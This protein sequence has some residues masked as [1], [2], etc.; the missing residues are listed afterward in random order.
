MAEWKLIIFSGSDASLNNLFVKSNITNKGTVA[1]THLTG[2]FTGSFRGDGSQLT[3]LTVSAVSSYTNPGNDRIITSVDAT[4]ING[5]ANLTFN[6]SVLGV[7]GQINASSYITGSRLRLST[8]PADGAGEATVLVIDANGNVKSDEIDTRVW[9]TTLVDYTGTPAASR[10]AY[11]SDGDTITA[12]PSMSFA[13][14]RMRVTGSLIVNGAITGS[15]IRLN[16][17]AAGLDNTVLVIT[18]TGQVVTDEIDARVWGTTLVDGTG[19]ANRLAYWS[20]ADSLT[21]NANLSFD[22]SNLRVTGSVKV[23]GA[24]TGSNIRLNNLAAGLDNTVLVVTAT[25]QVVTDEIDARVWGT[26]LVDGTGANTRVAYWSDADTLTSAA[27]FTYNGTVVQVGNSTFGTNTFVAGN[28]LVAGT[29]SFQHT[30]TL[31]VSDRFILLNSGSNTGDGGI[32]IQSGSNGRGVAFGWD[33]SANR[34]GYQL[35]RQMNATGSVMATDAYAAVVLDVDGGMTENNM[36]R[37]VG[38]IKI[39]GAAAYIYV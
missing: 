12:T 31:L 17:L 37:K 16:N 20:D 26:T 21:S 18:S 28:L 36:H 1:G 8:A 24:I 11:W 33:Y 27:G 6:G 13:A 2:S 34:F 7:T 23:N 30:N 4:T 10:L 15:N 14:G 38:N 35:V 19:A 5:E 22:G 29:A 3:G 32:I 25:G 39:E 9:G